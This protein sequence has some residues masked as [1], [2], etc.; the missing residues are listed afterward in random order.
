M[1]EFTQEIAKSLYESFFFTIMIAILIARIKIYYMKN[2]YIIATKKFYRHN[3]SRINSL[4]SRINTW[5]T[6]N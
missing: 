5:R 2:I 6:A 1:P 3:I 4:Y